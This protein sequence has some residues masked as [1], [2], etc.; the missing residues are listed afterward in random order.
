[1]NR[2]LI[3][4]VVLVLLLG[5]AAWAFLGSAGQ[6]VQAAK[7]TVKPLSEFVDEEGK[8]RLPTVHMVTM[9]FAG[10][11]EEIALAEGD[12]VE[13]RQVVAQVSK[14]D[15]EDAVAEAKAAVERLDASIAENR[16]NSVENNSLQQAKYFVESMASTVAAAHARLTAGQERMK[17]AESHLGRTLETG[18]ATSEDR[19]E[20]AQLDF[21]ESKVNYQQDRLVHSAVQAVESATKLLPEMITSYIDRKSLSRAVL[22][23]Q[24]EEAEARLRQMVI[25]QERGSMTSPIAGV[26]LDRPENSERFVASGEM[27]MTLG[28]LNQLEVEAEFLSQDVVRMK[29]GDAAEV[30]GPAIGGNLG[31]GVRGVVDRISKAGFTKLSS[32]GVEQQRVT[33]VIRFDQTAEQSLVTRLKKERNIDLGVGFRVRVRAF[34]RSKQDAIVIPRSAILRGA[35]GEWQVFAV[36]SNLAELRNIELGLMN[37]DEVEV[38]N[39]LAKDDL[40]I[41]APESRLVGG[42]KVAPV[43]RGEKQ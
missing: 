26:V 3:I 25:R 39:G 41:L 30:Y 38:V 6:T 16:D 27:L 17:F 35:D 12:A 43:V 37:D 32:L 10:K 40:V 22:E 11:I 15:L 42:A 28:D 7:A 4:G 18:R 5:A 21:V 13:V 23:K 8:T 9:P 24:K 20:Q 33:V 1:M 2:W 29:P 31:Y 14:K 34:T 36:V 19:K